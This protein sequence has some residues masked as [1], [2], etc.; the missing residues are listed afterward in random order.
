MR[1]GVVV[2]LSLCVLA[3]AQGRGR[4]NNN[5][6][7][8]L[9]DQKKVEQ[10]TNLR[11]DLRELAAKSPGGVARPSD[12]KRLLKLISEVK[13]P[14]AVRTLIDYLDTDEYIPV[15][16]YILELLAGISGEEATITQVMQEHVRPSDPQRATARKYLLD[17]AERRRKDEWPQRLFYA[18]GTA[19]DRFL[20]LQVMGKIKGEHTLECASVLQRDKSWSPDGGLMS[21]GTI[22]KSL[23]SFEG[24]DAAEL[25]LLLATDPRFTAAD[26]A[27]VR[28][29]TRSWM[30]TDL[31]TYV[32]LSDLSDPAKRADAAAFYGAVGIEAARAPLMRVAFNKREVPEFRA[33]AATALGGLRIAR[34]DLAERLATLLSDPDITIRRGALEGLGRLKVKQAVQAIDSMLDGPYADDALAALPRIMNNKPAK[35]DW[36]SWL[37]TVIASHGVPPAPPAPPAPQTPPK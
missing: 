2:L 25:L 18:A 8:D 13:H 3:S 26:A 27:K 22:A 24:Q 33:A 32:K 21:C 28:E 19:E 5:K 20:A 16:G 4:N 34:E 11:H 35:V 14:Q 17:Q 36:R 12:Q 9:E 23:E 6:G 15:R 30:Q 31:R 1:R 7:K 29:A 10:I 37:K